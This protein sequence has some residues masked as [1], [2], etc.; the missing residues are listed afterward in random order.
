MLVG[1]ESLVRRKV[2]PLTEEEE[3][4]KALGSSA[5]EMSHTGCL[6]G[7]VSSGSEK[8]HAG[9]VSRDGVTLQHDSRGSINNNP[10]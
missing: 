2:T 8:R 9:A 4:N 3:L 7:E 5:E 1:T 10:T 6:H